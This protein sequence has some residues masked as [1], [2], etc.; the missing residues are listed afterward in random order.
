MQR[1]DEFRIYYNHTIHPELI[2]LERKRKRLL[3]LIAFSIVLIAVLIAIGIYLHILPLTLFM[4]LPISFYVAYLVNEIRK[5]V[6]TFKPQIVNLILDFIDDGVNYG[7]L[8]Y[9]AE[10]SIS[11]STFNKSR[12]FMSP[13]VQFVGEDYIS[14]KLGELDFEMSELNVREYSRARSRLNYVFRGVFL[15]STFT[16]PLRGSILILPQKFRQYLSRT[17]KEF[18]RIGGY[19]VDSGLE[20]EL[21]TLNFMTYA[22]PDAFVSGVLSPEMQKGI[23]EYKLKSGKEIYISF[24]GQEIYVAITEPKD[25][26]EPFIFQSNISFD[27]VKD[28]FEDISMLL[29]IVEDFDKN[30]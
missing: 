27:L 26:L 20:N 7:T 16:R 6:S 8:K 24:I 17:I 25:I 11:R 19:E 18:V 3:K 14:G 9:E 10:K 15:H 28:F 23:V 2:R 22:T 1:L 4:M 30:H 21:F 29:S 12:I 13:A 5:F